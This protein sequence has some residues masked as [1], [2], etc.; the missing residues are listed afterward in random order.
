MKN[1]RRIVGVGMMVMA[2]AARAADGVW[3]AGSGVWTNTEKWAAGVLPDAGGAAAFTGSGGTVTVPAGYPFNLSALYFNT[4]GVVLNWTLMGET[5]ALV[6]PALVRI[7]NPINTLFMNAAMAGINGFQKTGDGTLKI[8][9]TNPLLSGSVQ[10]LGGR[11]LIRADDNLGQV[12][13]SYQADALV[14]DTGAIGNDDPTLTLALTRGVTLGA[15]GGYLFGRNGND[16][17]MASPITGAGS[18]YVNMQTGYVVLSNTNNNYTGDTVIGASGPGYSGGQL[19]VLKLGA[20]EVLPHGAGAGGLV[21]DGTQ[22]GVLDLN[23]KT[24]TVNRLTGLGAAVLANSSSLTGVLRAGADDSDTI[25]SGSLQ[26][27]AVLDKI[28]TGTL[29][30]SNMA[31][32]AGSI[33]ISDGAVRAASAQSLGTVTVIMAG[34]T[35]KTPVQGPPQRFAASLLLATNGV[36][37]RTLATAAIVWG[38]DVAAADGVTNTTLLTV[39]GGSEPFSIGATNRSVVFNADVA[40]PN[41]VLFRDRVWLARLPLSSTWS[42]APGADL[43]IGNAGLLGTGAMTLTNFSVRLP[44]TDAL[45]VGGETVTVGGISNAVWFDATRLAGPAVTN[46]PSYAFTASNS[47]ILSGTSAR[48]GFGGAGTVTYTGSVSGSGTLVKSGSGD[49]VLA[50]ANTFT[51]DIQLNAGSLRV[52]DDGQLGNSANPLMLAGGYL[53]NASG[54]NVTLPRTVQAT[55]G[56]FDV[57]DASLNLSGVVSG[58]AS[59]RG[60]GTLTLSGSSANPA[61]DLAVT[62]GA[63]LLSKSGASAVRNLTVAPSGTAR[64]AGTGGNQISGNV[65]LTGGALDLNGFSETVGRLDSAALASSVTNG[66]ASAA[67][68]TVGEG[69]VGG[70]YYGAL[71]DGASLGLTKTGT[72]LFTLAGAAG[73]QTASGGLR[74]EGGTLALGTGVRYVRVSPGTARAPGTLPAMGEFQLLFKGRPL[75]WPAGTTNIVTSSSSTNVAVRLI[76]NNSRTYWQAGSLP[77]SATIDMKRTVLC[78]GY[79]WYT[80]SDV[81]DRDP[82]NW[83]VEVSADNANWFMADAR[84]NQTVVTT[85]GTLASARAFTGAWPNDAV[86]SASGLYVASGAVVRVTLPEESV[87]GLTGSGEVALAAGASL[88]VADAGSYA[89]TV[90]GEGRLLLGGNAS[91]GVPSAASVVNVVNDGPFAAA[92]TVGANNEPLFGAALADGSS[93]LGLTKQGSGTLT[94]VDAGSTYSGDTRVEA[95]TLNVQAPMWRFRYI[96]FNPSMTVNNNVPFASYALCISEFQLTSNGVSVAY[97]VGS[98][99]TTLYANNTGSPSSNAINGLTTGSDRWLSPVIPNP[100]TIDAKSA[101]TFNGYRWF[102]SGNNAGDY[103]RA[104]TAWTVEGSY[105]GITWMTLCGESGVPIP[106]FTANVGNEVGPFLASPA[107]FKLTADFYAETNSA[108]LKLAAVSARYLRFTPTA[109]RNEVGTFDF[110]SSGFQLAELQL[111]RDGVPVSYPAG[112]LATASGGSYA[113]SYP[114]GKAVDG[115]IVGSVNN[116]WYSDVMVNPLTVDMQQAVA[117]N[118]YRWYTAYNTPNRDPVGWTL[119]VSNNTTNWYTVD[120]RTN[121]TV[122]TDRNVAAGT[123]ALD[124]P[125]GQRAADTIP[126]ASRTLVATGATLRLDAGSE[127]VGPLSGTGTVTLVQGAMFGING[128]T[129]AAYAGGITGTGTVVKT[130]VA[131]Q[132]LSGALAFSGAL[133]V[134]A[135]TLDL[136][137]ATLNGVTNIVLRSGG[138]LA[139]AA[140]VNGNLTIAAEGGATRA[141]LAVTGALTVTGTL[142][143][144][145]PAGA[146]MPYAQRLFAFGSADAATRAALHASAGTLAVPVGFAASVHVTADAAYLSVSAPGTVLLVR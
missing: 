112:T 124:L 133:L 22:K 141:N 46:D 51:G 24:E 129:N 89:G 52:S 41:G 88:R 23:G 44:A 90:S 142:K 67:V 8:T 48:V 18:L 92:V 5:N 82:L 50:T 10:V 135:G 42:I 84:T 30:Y 106:G 111:L 78:D 29:T 73:T 116:R 114:P 118:A 75:A 72:N 57:Q 31:A 54:A 138:E 36:L 87:A 53:G 130:G 17:V 32:S 121:Q 128:F 85:R 45:G 86:S 139:G 62:Q 99:A 12:P 108:A 97:P 79:R 102:T 13:A 39:S 37:D 143:L 2:F 26:A 120:V 109:A 144:A 33:R 105:D 14:L 95:G 80:C 107:R 94:M 100:L 117:F 77:A 146:V 28:G 83:T 38:G 71:A 19:A 9:T 74:A 104:P 56:G 145:L 68:L 125:A 76:D 113:N 20:D 60:G 63:A 119:E 55:A 131:V 34:G 122:T 3:T 59:K 43:T 115:D 123:W 11:L 16:M 127:T 58:T 98:T 7:D 91:L 81:S 101:V 6:A 96:R 4:N 25:F 70:T 134:N 69:G 66:G 126:D 93:A 40:D 136:A 35:L 49:A 15:G 103:N 110:G 132:T 27:G 140:A 137:G 1:M 61:L 21:I 47:V 64:L 65:T